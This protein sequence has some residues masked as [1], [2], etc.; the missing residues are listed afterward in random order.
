MPVIGHILWYGN[1]LAYMQAL[2]ILTAG[3]VHVAPALQLALGAISMNKLHTTFA[4]VGCD[5]EKGMHVS[6][7]L[8]EHARAFCG[9]SV[10][11]LIRVGEESGRLDRAFEQVVV[12]YQQRLEKTSSL[13]TTLVQPLLMIVLGLMI[14]GLIFAVYVPIFNLSEVIS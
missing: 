8:N 6:R 13:V 9:P 12:V 3:G 7:A 1:L 11:A 5:V 4:T 2:A 14:T 10:I